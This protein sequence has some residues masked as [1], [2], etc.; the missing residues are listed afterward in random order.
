MLLI[1]GRGAHNQF[2]AGAAEALEPAVTCFTW[3]A[4]D[5]QP[6][7]GVRYWDVETGAASVYLPFGLESVSGQGGTVSRWRALAN[8]FAWLDAPNR[9]EDDG[10]APLAFRLDPA[11]PNPF[12]GAARLSLDLPQD[13]TVEL[14][15]FDL[16]GRRVWLGRLGGTAGGNRYDL[17]VGTIGSGLYFLR[18][19]AGSYTAERT[20]TLLK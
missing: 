14:E 13:G 10:A 5:G 18:A 8:I 15:L 19:T 6:G 7:A 1:G 12:N 17:D 3:E 4:A 20:V 11:Y 16:A 9:A 2:H